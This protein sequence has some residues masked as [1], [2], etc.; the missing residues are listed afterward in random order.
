MAAEAAMYAPPTIVQDC[1]K[2]RDTFFH[3]HA[4]FR[5]R[6]GFVMLTEEQFIRELTAAQNRLFALILTLL[7]DPH[8]AQDVLQET[9]VEMW[10]KRGD[11]TPGT[12]FLAWACKIA[13][14][15]VLTHRGTHAR[16]RLIF[17]EGLVAQ[18]ATESEELCTTDTEQHDAL[19]HCLEHLSPRKRELIHE[20]YGKGESVKRLADRLGRS[21]SG[22]AV[23]L[24]RIRQALLDCV[25][26]QLTKEAVL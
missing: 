4:D 21:P 18:L 9:H 1:E 5:Q 10:R 17:D 20:R 16:Q 8:A 19:R 7:P 6:L 15:K 25:E 14:Y 11:F 3:S 2:R 13:R 23:S 24:F 12:N 26:R 22:L